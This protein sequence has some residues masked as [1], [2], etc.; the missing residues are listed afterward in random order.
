MNTTVIFNFLRE[1]RSNNNREWFHQNKSKYEEAREAFEELLTRVIARISTFDESVAKIQPNECTY[2]IYRDTRFSADKTPYKIHLGGYINAF[3]KKSNHFGY[4]IH[5]QPG[6]SMLA[7]GSIC[8]PPK[9]LRAIRQ[10]IVDNLE[11]YR[12][13]VEDP[14]FKRFFP[15]V[16]DDF[17][18]KMPKGFPTDFPYPDYLKCREYTCA[19]RVDDSFFDSPDFL[20]QTETV[21]RQMKRLADFINE[22]VDDLDE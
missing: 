2:R 14:A 18:K 9:V 8:L 12:E 13:I 20:D 6:E 15:I 11:E 4:Y 10:S 21:F 16:G 5:L 1:I 22:T 19:F 7:G 3:G 17:L